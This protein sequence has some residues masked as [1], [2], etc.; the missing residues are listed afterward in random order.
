MDD[1]RR[2]NAQLPV[3]VAALRA[4]V[5]HLEAL[6]AE[7]WRAEQVQSALYRIADAASAA[8]ELAD[9]YAAMHS[10]L[11]ELLYANHFY[12]A[13]YDDARQM[14]SFPFYVDE[15][16]TEDWPTPHAWFPI[17]ADYTRGMTGYVLRTGRPALITPEVYAE[18]SR[19]GEIE[20]VG[21]PP[22][23]FLGVPLKTE[24]RTLGVVAVQ[25]YREDIR[26]TEQDKALLTFVGQH[27]A[28]AL[29][30]ARAIEETRQRNAEL[31]IVNEVGQALAQ[32][33]DFQAIIELVGERVRAI[34]DAPDIWIGFYDRQTNLIHYPYQIDHGER[35][36]REPLELGQGLT[37][38]V[39]HSRRPLALGTW[40][41]QLKLGVVPTPGDI[42]Q[43]PAE[44]WL[45]VPIVAGDDVIGVVSVHRLEQHAFSESDVRLLSTLASS[46]SVALENARLFDET[47]RLLAET[48]QRN[49]ELAIINSVQQ[50]LAAQLDFQAIVDLVGDKL[51]TVFLS[52]AV[53]I[54]LYD[55]QADLIHFPYYLHRGERITFPSRM[56]GAGLTSHVMRSR[57]PLLINENAEQRYAELGALFVGA[58]DD[59]KSW[60][61]VPIIA[62]DEATGAIFLQ[63][64]EREQAFSES[65]VRLLSTLGASLGVA[66]EN[67]RLF[68]EIQ[69]LF[70]AEQQRAAELAII[71]SVGEAMT[72]QLDVSTITRIVGDKVRAIFAVEVTSITLFDAQTNLLSEVYYYDKGYDPEGTWPLGQ[73]LISIVIQ[74]RQPLVLGTKQEGLERGAIWVTMVEGETQIGPA[75]EENQSESWLGVPIVVGERVLGVVNVQSYRQHAFDERSVRLLSTLAAS[76]GVAIENARLFEAERTQARRQ[77]ALFRL[78]G[79]LAAAPDEQAICQALVD[80]LRDD[81]LGYAYVGVFLVDKASG[82]RVL[83]TAAGLSTAEI[84]LRLRAGQGLSE[85]ALDGRLHY[86]P[87]VTREAQYVP[88]LN[89]GSE[90]DVPI[91]IG[92]AVAGV[93]VVESRQPG[94]FSQADFDVL[95]AAATQTGVALGRARSLAETEQRAAELAIINSVQQGLAAQ[96]DFQ[97]I[98]DLVGDNISETFKTDCTYIGLYD[99]QTQIVHFPYYVEGGYRH[100]I[101]PNQPGA[102]PPGLTRLVVESRQPMLLGTRD[103]QGQY[104]AIPVRTPGEQADTKETYL[105]VPILLG[106][107]VMGLVSVQ[108]YQQRAYGDRDVRLLTTL[109]CSMAVA[110]ENARLFDETQRLFQAEQQRAAEL[111][112]INSVQQ[113]LAAQLDMQAMYDLVGDKIREIFDAQVVNIS[114]YDRAADLLHF[115]YTIERSARFYDEPMALFG[116]RKHVIET[117]QPLLINQDV[118]Q[119]SADFG[120]LILSGEAAKSC[121]FVPMIVGDAATGVISLQNLDREHAFNEADVRLLSTLAA[122][123]AVALEN[124]RLF[125][126][127]KRL[128]AETEQRAAELETVNRIGQ[129]L[130][131]ELELDAL[132][133]LTGE[134]VRQTFAADI[135]YV[136]LYDRAT[137]MIHFPYEYGDTLSSIR[138]GEGLTSRIIATG[139]PL[140]IN[141]DVAGRHSALQVAPVGVSAKSFL[142]VPIM[143]G[144]AAIGVISVQSTRQEGRFGESDVHVLSTV[145]A[146]VGAAIANARLYQETQR[147]AREMAALAEVGREISASLDLPTVLRRIAE[148]AQEL[149]H[150]RDVVLRLLEPDGRLPAVVAL[151]KYAEIYKAWQVQLGYGLTGHIAQTGVAEIV[152]DPQDD[153]RVASIPGAEEDDATEAMLFAPLL[154]REQ[155]IGVMTVWRDKTVSGAFSQAELDFTVGLA[156]QATIAIENARLFDEIQQQKQFSEALIEA[157]PV[158]IILADLNSYVTS[159]NPAAETLFGYTRAE[160]LGRHLDDLVANRPDIRQE[161]DRYTPATPATYQGTGHH[162]IGRRTRKDG[163]LVDV[164]FFSVPVIVGGQIVAAITIYHDI[165][166]LNKARQEA[167]AANEAKSTFLANMSHELRTPL[168]A[169]IGFT[170]IVRRKAEGALPDKQLDNLDKVLSSGEHLLSLINTV[171]DIAKIEAGRMD[172]QPA[173]FNAAGLVEGCATTTRPLLRPGVTLVKELPA[174][175]PL[176]FSDQDKVKQILLN[177]LSNAAKFTHAGTIT[178]R[179][180]RINDERRTMNSDEARAHAL[181]VHRSS[182]IVFE[183]IDTGIGISEEALGRV[184]EEFQQADT[185]TTRQYGGTG[186]GLSI[187][188]HLARL[189]G[190]DLTASSTP[191]NGSTFTLTIPAQY[192]EQKAPSETARPDTAPVAL[193]AEKPIVLAIDDDADAIEILQ[194]NLGDAGYQVVGARGGD[195]GVLKAKQLRPYA[196][197]LD[198]MMPGKDGWQVLHEL[199]SD[200][201]TRDIPVILLTIV[202]KKALGYQLGA[203]DYLVKPLDREALL[204]ALGRMA[205]ANGGIA[206]KRL[207]VVDDDPNVIEMV[208]QLLGETP[209]EVHAAADGLAALDAIARRRPDAILLDLM[210]PRMDGFGVIERLRQRPE[211]ASIPIVVL[212]AKTL[213]GEES[214]RLKE[215]VAQVMQKQGLEGE[216][217]IRELQRM[218]QAPHTSSTTD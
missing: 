217:L 178:L 79:A 194:D 81:D 14:L 9:F 159:W 64:Y 71:N 73:G 120:N 124:A 176:V 142:G 54:A 103:E 203:S 39:I 208:Q 196:I 123:L 7:R 139:Q 171:L 127:T 204:A 185:S 3:E 174:D 60:L 32:Q 38:I 78:S 145:A 83:R 97:A 155:V 130:A 107:E 15:V 40:A 149:L 193:T 170:R 6:E 180:R 164:E 154:T 157:S 98:I 121:I 61:G 77:A 67:A 184:F 82:E 17:G 41:E 131:S 45:G 213:T 187:S 162:G 211:S 75:P 144:D 106:D 29:S 117:Q 158:A 94:A 195:E 28:T 138:F 10:I 24:G 8:T 197:T 50:G 215:S 74:S 200:P 133:Q 46:M 136:G 36:S 116:F 62:G 93:L 63:N 25:S 102:D 99:R 177:L 132:I 126:E 12:I 80:G 167:I 55:R 56:F 86:T 207:L 166:E 212:T 192:G 140:L 111:A 108:R 214:A 11:G 150:G 189:L 87:D 42:E 101:G 19:Q 105:G 147:H 169:I 100:D 57:E 151:G 34:F 84:G 49:T 92:A 152:N 172:V 209:Y 218:L 13:L 199:K 129:A 125:D 58:D 104:G 175:L 202:D 191:G 33:L 183:V 5:A 35:Y 2:T 20:Q 91:P 90:V 88:A 141:K 148:H 21:V 128:L 1:Q 118:A 53:T 18:L 66:L 85:R 113:G 190:G 210:M 160:A 27:I 179:V 51:R 206:P 16:D 146:N 59:A 70:Q 48:Q 110:L 95:T 37:S 165:T 69:R 205:Q 198:I 122:S 188:R 186:L 89:S 119:R 65:D 31:A 156:R 161:A 216:T 4:R 163:Q 201:A 44:S 68:D 23:D 30:R 76:M 153:P 22:V 134:Q 112:L 52:E 96:L 137:G 181:I 26:Y 173:N 47:K 114:V 168:N 182:F 115:P 135:A 143:V 43:S 72:Q 109:A